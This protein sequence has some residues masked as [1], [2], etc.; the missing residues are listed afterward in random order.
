MSTSAKKSFATDFV[1]LLV[2]EIPEKEQLF[3]IQINSESQI[4]RQVALQP[5]GLQSYF[6]RNLLDA[7]T[8]YF[9]TPATYNGEEGR[10]AKN[11]NALYAIVVDVD[12]SE[13]N[14][15]HSDGR[16]VTPGQLMTMV[17]GK[18]MSEAILNPN[19]VVNTG[20]GVQIWWMIRRMEGSAENQQLW[21]EAAK[22]IINQVEAFVSRLYMNCKPELGGF[23][24]DYEASER[25]NGC[26]RLPGTFNPKTGTEVEAAIFHKRLHVIE[27]FWFG[28]EVLHGSVQVPKNSPTYIPEEIIIPWS[29]DMLKKLEDLRGHRNATPGNELRSEFCCIYLSLLKNLPY[30]DDEIDAAIN[31]FNDG[32]KEPLT[33]SELKNALASA[34]KK[35]YKYSTQAIIK[36]LHILPEELKVLGIKSVRKN[37]SAARRNQDFIQRFKEGSSIQDIATETGYSWHTVQRV[38]NECELPK[39]KEKVI[40][41]FKNDV[42]VADIAAQTNYTRRHVN[43]IINEYKKEQEVEPSSRQDIFVDSYNNVANAEDSRIIPISLEGVEQTH[44]LEDDIGKDIF[45]KSL[46]NVAELESN[47]VLLSC[48]EEEAKIRSLEDRDKQNTYADAYYSKNNDALLS[49]LSDEGIVN[50]HKGVEVKGPIHDGV[51]EGE[52]HRPFSPDKDDD[53]CSTKY[54]AFERAKMPLSPAL[55]LMRDKLKKRY[56]TGLSEE[57]FDKHFT[58]LCEKICLSGEPKKEDIEA[59][60]SAHPSKELDEMYLYLLGL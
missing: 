58:L 9:V 38:V 48:P 34:R 44:C 16:K 55:I 21:L 41:L 22:H 35:G 36:H 13:D 12:C 18:D 46:N 47:T 37:V 17:S 43:R 20:R 60:F 31:R 27:D 33:P 6:H 26:F 10:T 23:R 56:G 29:Q 57:E 4:T 45:V 15:N 54:A 50:G 8:D 24:V 32:F 52:T 11:I 49:A 5:K 53:I 40:E 14:L 25:L 1:N 19:A 51:S 30:T 7:K 3:L 28:K 2:A 42:P 59:E 39:R